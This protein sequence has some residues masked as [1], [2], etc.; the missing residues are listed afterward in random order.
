MVVIASEA[1]QSGRKEDWI[2]SAA[3]LLAMTNLP[4]LLQKVVAQ[5]S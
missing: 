3:T 4:G 1:K 2:A 5:N